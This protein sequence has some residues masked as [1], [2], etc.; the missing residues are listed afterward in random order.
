MIP[1]STPRPGKTQALLSDSADKAEI[2]DLRQLYAYGKSVNRGWRMGPTVLLIKDKIE[3]NGERTQCLSVNV[4]N[5]NGTTT[6][7]SLATERLVRT[8]ARRFTADQHHP[9]EVKEALN[10]IFC[11]LATS[12]QV[13]LDRAFL[14]DLK[15]LIYPPLDL[16]PTSRVILRELRHSAAA[17]QIAADADVQTIAEVIRSLDSLGQQRFRYQLEIRPNLGAAAKQLLAALHP[18]AQTATFKASAK[19][20]RDEVS[21]SLERPQEPEWTLGMLP[22]HSKESA[23]SMHFIEV[24]D[25][26]VKTPPASAPLGQSFI[27]RF[28]AQIQVPA[29]ERWV[30]VAP[31]TTV[32]AL[33]AAIEW[34][35]DD[36]L[37]RFKSDLQLA[38]GGS[39]TDEVRVTARQLLEEMG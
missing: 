20:Q 14:K 16:A 31:H 37:A 30:T 2:F 23:A 4:Q 18:K 8:L 12:N 10:S 19:Q 6:S 9:L 15:V 24:P 13:V 32:K 26:P 36:Q 11:R 34:L 38:A 1:R 17:D 21:E 27:K 33:A 28:G 7:S 35:P 22:Y 5:A 3:P 25:Q 29:I 39:Y